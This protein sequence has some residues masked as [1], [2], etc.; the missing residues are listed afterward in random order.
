ML[1]TLRITN[2][3]QSHSGAQYLIRTSKFLFPG[4]AGKGLGGGPFKPDHKVRH[5]HFQFVLR[6]CRHCAYCYERAAGMPHICETA[7]SLLNVDT[8]LLISASPGPACTWHIPPICTMKAALG[9]LL[10]ARVASFHLLLSSSP[11]ASQ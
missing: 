10:R 5:T 9:V 8:V 2:F 6:I 11:P 4:S 3:V 1:V 7:S